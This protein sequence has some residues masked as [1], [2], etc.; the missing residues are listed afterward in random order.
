M[1]GVQEVEQLF[2]QHGVAME[3]TKLP[4]RRGVL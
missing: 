3:T 2:I 4:L 1:I